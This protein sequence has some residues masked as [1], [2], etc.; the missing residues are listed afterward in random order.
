M[1]S[2]QSGRQQRVSLLGMI[3]MLVLLLALTHSVYAPKA[4]ALLKDVLGPVLSSPTEEDENS[5]QV[6]ERSATTGNSGLLSLPEIKLELP[7]IKVDTPIVK[8]ETPPVTVETGPDLRDTKVDVPSIKVDTPIIRAETPKVEANTKS[9]VPEVKVTVPEV[10]VKTPIIRAQTPEVKVDV[11]PEPVIPDIKVTV[12]RGE[13]KTPIVEVETP[14]VEVH[15]PPVAPGKQP[16]EPTEILP[17]QP[18]PT[19]NPNQIG[20]Q[21]VDQEPASATPVP[22]T[23]SA[24]EA[25]VVE[26]EMNSGQPEQPVELELPFELMPTTEQTELEA[27]TGAG[28][29]P[30]QPDQVVSQPGADAKVEDR[31]SAVDG[32]RAEPQSQERQ[33]PLR[34]PVTALP[35]VWSSSGSS[36]TP[37]QQGGG[38]GGS[39]SAGGGGPTAPIHLTEAAAPGLPSVN[40]IRLSNLYLLGKDQWCQPPPGQPPMYAFFSIYCDV[41]TFTT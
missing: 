13:V 1:T 25:P 30:A 10:E 36:V 40:G 33:Q 6:Q 17:V 7:T 16:S 26:P 22:G 3:G 35:P 24:P 20:V 31:V 38:L 29:H 27:V 34:Q 28:V 19:E 41:T 39:P 8:V 23:P 37:G 18:Q 11:K 14:A 21:P 15:V 5:E 32:Q 9:V 4:S 12:P 2:G